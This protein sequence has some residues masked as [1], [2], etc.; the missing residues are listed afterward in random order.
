MR[1]T[2]VPK[3]NLQRKSEPPDAGRFLYFWPPDACPERNER[4]CI[5]EINS[6]SANFRTSPF[7]GLPIHPDAIHGIPVSHHLASADEQATELASG[8]NGPVS[9]GCK[10]IAYLVDL[11]GERGSI[12]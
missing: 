10:Q 1:G 6:Q 5:N 11:V 12:H 2:G 4:T 9:S 3:Q 8:S 7:P